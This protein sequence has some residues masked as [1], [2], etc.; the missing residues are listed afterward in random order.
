MYPIRQK[1]WVNQKFWKNYISFQ[2]DIEIRHNFGICWSDP[3]LINCVWICSSWTIIFIHKR[4]LF[5]NLLVK[6]LFLTDTRILVCWSTSFWQVNSKRDRSKFNYAITLANALNYT[7]QQI[8][9]LNV[10][11]FD[12]YLN[13][14]IRT[15]KG[16]DA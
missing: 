8:K 9:C 2:R 7:W 14:I 16:C 10:F 11:L 1:L 12:C 4:I 13:L 6:V 3:Q 5:P 15:R